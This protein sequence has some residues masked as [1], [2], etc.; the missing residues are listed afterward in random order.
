MTEAAAASGGIRQRSRI[1]PAANRTAANRTP[2]SPTQGDGDMSWMHQGSDGDAAEAAERERRAKEAEERARKQ[3]VP[4]RFSLRAGEQA[5]AIILD[6]QLG[7]RFY[8]HERYRKDAPRGQKFTYECCPGEWDSCPCCEGVGGFSQRGFVMM[9]TVL[10]L[11][12]YTYPADHRYKPN[13]TVPVTKKLMAVKLEQQGFFKRR[14]EQ[15]G[16]LRGMHLLMT[17]DTQTVSKIGNPEYQDQYD[18]ATLLAEY[19]H[20]AELDRDGNVLRPANDILMP[21]NYG[22]I[23]PKPSGADLRH[24]YGGNAPAGSRE[25]NEEWQNNG[26]GQSTQQ[27]GSQ[28]QSR[29]EG[30]ASSGIRS[31]ANTT[32]A[33]S[34]GDPDDVPL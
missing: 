5:D 23:F 19:G 25:D 4:I 16:T 14:L 9:L 12:P 8:E 11:T 32:R 30:Q 2:S 29:S 34:G 26:N 3:H 1:A 24:R 21:V 15:Q 22:I 28:G 31:R 18:D 33:A 27:G 6:S 7:P 10:D 17:R 13:L 20:D